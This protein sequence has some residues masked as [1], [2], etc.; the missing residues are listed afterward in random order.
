MMPFPLQ[1]ISA[2]AGTPVSM[3]SLAESS[4]G[5]FPAAIRAA[6]TRLGLSRSE[7][8]P[9]AAQVRK[10]STAQGKEKEEKSKIPDGTSVA[11]RD[12][13]PLWVL[14]QASGVPAERIT[15]FFKSLSADHPDGKMPMGELVSRTRTLIFSEFGGAGLVRLEP[16]SRLAVESGLTRAGVSP[17]EA[18]RIFSLSTTADG[19][20]DVEKFLRS[21]ALRGKPPLENPE[22]ELKP[23]RQG[24]ETRSTADLSARQGSTENP[25]NPDTPASRLKGSDAGRGP[26]AQAPPPGEGTEVANAVRQ[27][28]EGTGREGTILSFKAAER[29]AVPGTGTTGRGDG[30]A[31]VSG[32]PA[33][34]R[35]TEGPAWT[36]ASGNT[37]AESERARKSPSLSANRRLESEEQGAAGP[38]RSKGTNEGEALRRV[39]RESAPEDGRASV[40]TRTS[41]AVGSGLQQGAARPAAAQSPALPPSEDPVPA[42]VA[43]QVSKQISRALHSGDPFIRMHLNPP[44]L[45]TLKVRLEWS[46]EALKIEMVTDRHQSRDLILSSA[47]ELKEALGDQGFRV[48]KMEVVVHDPA[49]PSLSPSGG[50]HRHPSSHGTRPQEPSGTPSTERTGGDGPAEPSTPREGR[51]LDL[52]A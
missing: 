15:A 30:G 19:E 25:V 13:A 2:Q 41:P 6:R 16:R 10:P 48:E 49:G 34:S 44:E 51:L 1:M 20:V 22:K 18:E 45:G 27:A 28:G 36:P 8:G 52:V 9:W 21:A 7:G 33:S 12:V 17:K 47:S 5:D 26:V 11:I 31:A 32:E 43:A 24:V 23:A 14:L 40:E 4:R 50:E 3:K 46:Q 35:A 39:P 37:T 42:Y 38:T 29:K